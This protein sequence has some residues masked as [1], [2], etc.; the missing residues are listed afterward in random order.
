MICGPRFGRVPVIGG[1]ARRYSTLLAHDPEN[2]QQAG[3]AKLDERDRFPALTGRFPQLTHDH[4]RP[5]S[6]EIAAHAHPGPFIE[7]EPGFVLA[8]RPQARVSS[9]SPRTRNPQRR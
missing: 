6:L 3:R 8:D 5:A 1:Q 4:G 9:A 7:P 2:A